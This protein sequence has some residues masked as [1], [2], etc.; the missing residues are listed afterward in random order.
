[1]PAL[2]V[3][4]MKKSAPINVATLYTLYSKRPCYTIDGSNRIM[5]PS[6]WRIDGAPDRFFVALSPSE[7]HLKICPP[8]AFE[9]FLDELCGGTADKSKIPEIER[10]L[11]DRV[12]Q[13]SLDRFGRLA[14][15]REFTAK[16]GIEKH[17]EIVGRFSKF[18][19]WASDKREKQRAARQE[20]TETVDKKLLSL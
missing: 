17:G 12:R 16:A 11:N 7:D 1:M 13:V 10:E 6:E 2:R 20:T 5:L 3:W 8:E 4:A 14:L 19:I 18:E 9:T 15:P